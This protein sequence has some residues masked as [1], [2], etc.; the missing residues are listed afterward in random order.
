MP[1][2]PNTIILSLKFV[3]FC[4]SYSQLDSVA[5][6]RSPTGQQSPLALIT[7]ITL[8][9]FV[10]FK[11]FVFSWITIISELFQD[12]LP[13]C[14]PIL[15][16]V[17]KKQSLS[18]YIVLRGL[19]SEVIW[20]LTFLRLLV[21]L[22]GCEVECKLFLPATPLLCRVTCGKRHSCWWSECFHTVGSYR[23]GTM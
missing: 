5:L 20:L 10:S 17:R 22:G 23:V 6:P 2:T 19:H 7:L 16:I 13:I 1:V 9:E 3:P 12:V 21:Q 15:V 8:L 14:V 4:S 18:R 11:Y